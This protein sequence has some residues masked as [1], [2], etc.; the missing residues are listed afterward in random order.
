[1]PLQTLSRGLRPLVLLILA[2]LTACNPPVARVDQVA[3]D[4]PAEAG[5][6]VALPMQR[7]SGR[8]LVSVSFRRPDGGERRALAWLNMGAPAPVLSKELYRELGL[9][10]GRDLAMRI[11]AIGVTLGGRSVIDGPGRIGEQELFDL[12]FA[13]RRV[14]A[15]L[16]AGLLRHFVVTVDPGAATLTLARPGTQRPRGVP[17]PIRVNP[18]S[19]IAMADA[20]VDGRT[21]PLVLDV[22]AP[23]TWLRGRTVA[24]W[25]GRHPGW[26]RAEGAI[27]RANLAMADLDLEPAG[28]VI[29]LPRIDLAGLALTDV[30]ALGTGPVGGRLGEAALGEI[31]WDRWQAGVGEPVAGWL[32][33]NVFDT[34]RLTLD[35]ASGQSFWER[36]RASGPG[37]LDGIGLTL[38]R[39]DTGYA[40]AAVATQDGRPLVPGIEVGDRL[41][42]VDGHPLDGLAPEAALAAL[43]ARPGEQRVLELDR[44]GAVIRVEAEGAGF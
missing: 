17:V 32:G 8:W 36:Q 31:F 6:I 38:V 18:V 43:S 10:E 35:Y 22:G 1:M 4:W 25:L 15:V 37:D 5:D 7:A 28:T 19:G 3:L 12:I 26:R 16:P 14:E 33:N 13:P 24:T 41:L 20:W 40:V 27:G 2:L 11:G 21:V 29:R 34:V 44:S 23:F 9:T 30:G 39:R 42:R